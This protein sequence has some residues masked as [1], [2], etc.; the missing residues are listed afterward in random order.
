LKAITGSNG[1]EKMP[2]NPT[3]EYLWLAAAAIPIA[4]LFLFAVIVRL[5]AW[6]EDE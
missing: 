6:L 3:P 2:T 4:I 5:L 1:D